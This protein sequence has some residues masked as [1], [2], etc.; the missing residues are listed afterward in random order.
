MRH[1]GEMDDLFAGLW[2]IYRDA[3]L[4]QASDAELDIAHDAFY[5]GMIG[6]TK[7][8][9]RMRRSPSRLRE[10]IRDQARLIAILQVESRAERH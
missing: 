9:A 8:L 6:L 5:G 7:A 3:V 4:S 1:G 10:L 2:T